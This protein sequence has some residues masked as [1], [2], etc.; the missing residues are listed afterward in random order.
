VR[1]ILVLLAGLAASPTL[2]IAQSSRP[3]PAPSVLFAAAPCT[4]LRPALFEQRDSVKQAIRPTQWKKGAIIGGVVGALAGLLYTRTFGCGSERCTGFAM[5]AAVGG[6]I[7][8]AIP[9]ALIGG[10]FRKPD[11]DSRTTSPPIPERP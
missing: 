7:L 4:P 1:S 2:A 6:A 11:S 8:L 10:S 5:T 9:G 3:A